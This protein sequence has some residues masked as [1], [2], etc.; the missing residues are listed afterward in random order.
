MKRSSLF[1]VIIALSLFANCATYDIEMLNSKVP[2]YLTDASRPTENYRR[3]RFQ[4]QLTWVLFDTVNVQ[5]LDLDSAISEELPNA[6]KIIN[7]R[8]ESME[9][10]S[11]SLVRFL[12]TLIQYLLVT[13]RALFSRRTVIVEGELLE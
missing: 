7:L 3:F 4:R 11:D 8:V 12:G 9:S 13:D 10:G 1:A 2:V 6:K 5:K